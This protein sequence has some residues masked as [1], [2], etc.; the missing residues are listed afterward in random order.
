MK[1][2]KVKIKKR[3][4]YIKK[5]ILTILTVTWMGI[6]FFF[7]NQKAVASNNISDGIIDKIVIKTY[8]IFKNDISNVEKEFIKK[9]FTRPIRKIGHFFIYFILGTLVFFTLKSY[10]IK[11]FLVYYSILICYIYAISDEF[12]QLFILGRSCEILDVLLDTFSSSFS[13]LLFSKK[14]K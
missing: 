5:I 3:N 6:I 2:Q 11:T 14:S 4:N 9:Y 13:I 7:S 8:S 1:Q 10:N 12:H